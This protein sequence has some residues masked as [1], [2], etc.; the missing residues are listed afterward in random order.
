MNEIF[1]AK[2]GTYGA[3]L[4]AMRRC[5]LATVNQVS[6]DMEKLR[7]KMEKGGQELSLVDGKFLEDIREILGRIQGTLET[8]LK[9]F[10]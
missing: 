7:A 3:S 9:M 5:G 6:H 8:T 2:G 1:T 4:L 10:Y